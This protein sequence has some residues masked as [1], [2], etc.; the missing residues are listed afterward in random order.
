M[1][2]SVFSFGG[3]CRAGGDGGIVRS[4]YEGFGGEFLGGGGGAGIAQFD[5]GGV[6]RWI[7]HVEMPTVSKQSLDMFFVLLNY[8][9]D[10][11]QNVGNEEWNKMVGVVG[12]VEL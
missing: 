8:R 2:G 6:L 5:V 11:D 3:G 10:L 12:I 4:F 9:M 1:I 7:A